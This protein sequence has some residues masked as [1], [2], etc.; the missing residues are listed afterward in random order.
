M[1]DGP[2]DYLYRKGKKQKLVGSADNQLNDSRY[3]F[4]FSRG[5]LYNIDGFKYYIDEIED[6][7]GFNKNWHYLVTPERKEITIDYSPYRDMSEEEFEQKVR[8]YQRENNMTEDIKEILRLAGL[9]T[10]MSEDTN[11]DENQDGEDSPFTYGDENVAMVREE[12]DEV[13]FGH[14]D[15]SVYD[16]GYCKA[17]GAWMDPAGGVHSKD[18]EDPARMYED[19]V[20]EDFLAPPKTSKYDTDVEEEEDEDLGYDPELPGTSGL[21]GMP[22]TEPEDNY[23]LELDVRRN[24]LMKD[25]VE[26]Q[27][28]DED[29]FND[30][31]DRMVDIGDP[32]DYEEYDFEDEFARMLGPKFESIDINVLRK[33]AGL[34]PI[35]LV[36]EKRAE[37]DYDE[38]GEVES[39][40]DEWKG[41]RDKAIK[42]AVK[43]AIQEAVEPLGT[44]LSPEDQLRELSKRMRAARRGLGLANKLAGTDNIKHRSRVLSNLN[45]IR[46]NLRRVIKQVEQGLQGGKEAVA[47]NFSIKPQE[48][49]WEND[50]EELLNFVYWYKSQLPPVDPEKKREAWE[51]IKTQLSAKYPPPEGVDP[52]LSEDIGDSVD[53]YDP[54][55]FMN[56][57]AYYLVADEIGDE[58]QFGPH[59]EVLVPVQKVDGIIALLTDSGFEQGYD[60][61]I[62]DVEEDLQN[63]YNNCNMVDDFDTRFPV[64]ATSHPARE[65]GPAGAKHGDNP[66]R[67]PM[68]SRDKEEAD[69]YESYKLSYRRHRKLTPVPKDE[70]PRLS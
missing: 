32:E 53:D 29:E 18:E 69:I 1:K 33:M 65:L 20:E 7:E 57:K 42:D 26:E 52:Q 60:F 10:N 64:G 56:E 5:P 70:K 62:A 39:S 45:S 37:K 49:W 19:D 12:D 35:A 28:P 68:A 30:D 61:R 4:R 23:D 67:S 16:Q 17:C 50:P 58:M 13:S 36:R 41:S 59:D 24:P 11:D 63:G 8:E 40:E 15:C 6:A 34:E 38:D 55:E 47:E 27:D 44:G 54:F 31:E 21:K 3:D 43:E 9:Y 25:A 51:Q 46:A 48:R 22:R 14:E 66:M 2:E